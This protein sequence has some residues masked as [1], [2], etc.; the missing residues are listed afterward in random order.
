MQRYVKVSLPSVQ[1]M[2]L[3]L[4]TRGFIERRTGQARSIRP[5]IPREELPDLT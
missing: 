3:T 5:L 2:I 1:Q 4:E